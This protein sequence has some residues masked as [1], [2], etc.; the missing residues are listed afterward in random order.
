M[1]FF[2]LTISIKFIIFIILLHAL[3]IGLSYI[4]LREYKLIFLCLEVFILASLYFSWHLYRQL[5]QP[6]RLMMRGID[7]MRDQDFNVRL[8]ATG[9]PE[10]DKLIE[11]YNQMMDKLRQERTTQQEQHFFL[12]KLIKTSPICIIIFDFDGKITNANPK[13][14]T[15]L[16]LTE[17]ELI[18]Q[19]P[20]H[21]NNSFLNIIFSN[22]QKNNSSSNFL[23]STEGGKK[24]KVQQAR[25]IDRGFSRSFVMIEELTAEILEAEKKAYSKIIRMMAHEVNN[26]VGA[27]NSILDTTQQLEENADIANALQ[28]AIERNEHLNQFMRRLAEVVRLPEPQYQT[29][30][31]HFLIQNVVNLMTFKASEKNVTFIFEFDDTPLSISVD[32]V[33][34]EQVL[35]NILKNSIEAIENE[36][37]IK[38][39]TNFKEKFLTIEDTGKGIATAHLPQLFSPFFTSKVGGQ[40]I[41]LTLIREILNNH[42]FNFELKNSIHGGAIFKIWFGK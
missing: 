41:G 35:I 17:K 38:I 5:I 36:G 24:F 42:Q 14:L 30:S 12:E 19:F 6:L 4:V 2:K 31:L 37:I 29:I 28:V 11:L 7:A 21:L 39:T 16:A 3:V 23:I 25:F 26:S 20:N 22:I 27:V 40:G 34:I 9:S 32:V 15:L 18:G 33:Q 8:T 1:K 10:P 13:A